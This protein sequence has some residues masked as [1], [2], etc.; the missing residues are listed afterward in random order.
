MFATKS[1][2]DFK[3]RT[4]AE[5]RMDF[6]HKFWMPENKF[7]GKSCP[8]TTARLQKWRFLINVDLLWPLAGQQWS[9]W[10]WGAEWFSKGPAGA[11]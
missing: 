3:F 9:D 11:R 7:D 5:D 8:R 4:Q 6:S 10:E 1:L 2:S